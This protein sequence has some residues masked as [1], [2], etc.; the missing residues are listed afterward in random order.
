MDR[1]SKFVWEE[2]ELE[3]LDN[4]TDAVIRSFADTDPRTLYVS[5]D[6]LNVDDLKA[7]ARREGFSSIMQHLHTTIL[8][9][10]SAVDWMK[11]EASY[12]EKLTIPEGGPRQIEQ[13]GPNGAVVLAFYSDELIW[14]NRR[15]MDNGA[16]SDFPEYQP[17]LTISYRGAPA[18]IDKIKPYRGVLQFGPEVFEEIKQD[19]IAQ[20][21]DW[22]EIK[23]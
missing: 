19:Q 4:T 10:K 3:L 20:V 15:M 2:G 18:D 9:S 8:Y 23:L 17:H 14:R 11:M 21:P 6:L 1:S 16:S 12:V 22:P 7:W 13:F 5:R